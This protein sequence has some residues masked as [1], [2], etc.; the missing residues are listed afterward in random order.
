MSGSSRRTF[1]GLS[2]SLAVAKAAAIPIVETVYLVVYR[3]GEN[4]LAGQPL[5]KQPLREH[6]RYMLSLHREG[7][8]RHAGRFEDGSGGAAVF[9]AA[10]EASA[11][12]VVEKDPA[13]ISKVF[14]Y[15]LRRW[16]W[17]DWDKLPR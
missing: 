13:V 2:L 9:A 3:P 5:E 16:V 4:W 6:G 12:A 10:D 15:D 8:L 7:I 11:T 17:V 1:M 14:A